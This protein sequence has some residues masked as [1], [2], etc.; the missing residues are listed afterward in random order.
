VIGGSRH[1]VSGRYVLAGKYVRFAV[2]SY[3]RS[4]SLIIDPVLSYSTY[5]GGN[6]NDVGIGIDVDGQGNAYIAGW[7]NSTLNFPRVGARQ[8][9]L[10]GVIDAF[11]TKVSA[12]GKTFLYSTYLGGSG[13]DEAEG[14][15]V[16][17]LGDMYVTGYTNSM[18]FPTNSGTIGT[19]GGY[20]EFAVKLDP[21]GATLLYSRLIGGLSNDYAFGIA[22]DSLGDAYIAGQTN[23]GGATGLDITMDSLAP[24]GALAGTLTY[25]TGGDD[26]G[27]AIALDS[28]GNVWETGYVGASGLPPAT[29]AVTPIQG[30][31]GGGNHDAFVAKIRNPLGTPAVPSIAYITYFGGSG[32]DQGTG[33]AF[34]GSSN[35]VY[36]TGFTDSSDFPKAFPFQSSN[37][38]GVDAFIAKITTTGTPALAWSTYW[39]GSG[40]DH[41]T[42]IAVDAIG[43]AI[44]A[45]YT[46]SM[47]LPVSSAVQSTYGGDPH[48]AF[49]LKVNQFGSGVT[50][51]TYLGGTKDDEALGVATDASGYAYVTGYTA[52]ANF[53]TTGAAQSTLGGQQDAFA[54][55]VV[56]PPG[57]PTSTPTST[58]TATPTNTPTATATNTPMA[59][60]TPTLTPTGTPPP[61]STPLPTATFTPTATSTPVP[62]NTPVPTATATPVPP[63][64]NA[65]FSYVSVWYST[66]HIGNTQH[67]QI[68][69]KSHSKQGI[70]TTIQF[71]TG[72]QI[73]YYVETDKHGFWQ[74][75]FTV[76]GDTISMYSAQAVV[77]FQL[78][79]SNTTA[80]AFATFNVIK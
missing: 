47:D 24:N 69:A 1:T 15:A 11:V 12:D 37:A 39:G 34:Q 48:D 41:A 43:E 20:D 51:A 68:Q 52:S 59:T 26:A 3:D 67:V 35:D 28:A 42:S 66:I 13:T 50:Y 9:T 53:A 71:A 46:T 16:D 55:K 72:K 25:G 74:A 19:H 70:W 75:E 14:I 33:I 31:Y 62:T 77:L 38:G 4:K 73:A 21:T 63:Q 18:D 78:W 64:H 61:T 60:A 29:P 54:A 44:V 65:A 57:I 45:G 76:P 49:L 17:A 27:T 7:T 80:Q 36:V 6:N 5:I 30:T 23:S 32:D 22:I 8:S 2:G 56:D 79:K 40:D 58:V 10:A